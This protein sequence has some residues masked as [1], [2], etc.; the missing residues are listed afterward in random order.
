VVGL[1]YT[2]G[3]AELYFKTHYDRD[4]AFETI[5]SRLSEFNIVPYRSEQGCSYLGTVGG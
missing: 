2:C 3:G 1:N 4:M 5:K